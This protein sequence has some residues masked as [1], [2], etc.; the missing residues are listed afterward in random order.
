MTPTTHAPETLDVRT[1]ACQDRHARI[2]QT[3]ALLPE[4]GAF[5]LVNDHDPAPLRAHFE[6]RHAGAF[7]WNYLERGPQEWRVR[8]GR[9]RGVDA[10][11]GGC[12]SG[13]G[14]C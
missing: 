10:A 6:A 11:A 9:T 4:G 13:G 2:F 3:F 12:C 14:C 7:A 8:I 5:D 1:L